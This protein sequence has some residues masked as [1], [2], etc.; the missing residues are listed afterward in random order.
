MTSLPDTL[1]HEIGAVTQSRRNQLWNMSGLPDF[2]IRSRDVPENGPAVLLPVKTTTLTFLSLST[3][4]M[5][6]IRLSI[7]LCEREFLVSG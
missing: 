3:I 5:A 7:T 2:D 4:A 1:L 6:D